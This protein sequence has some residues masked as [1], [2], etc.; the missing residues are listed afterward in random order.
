MFNAVVYAIKNYFLKV[1]YILKIIFIEWNL[2][3]Q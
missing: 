1:M 3:Y 2:Y